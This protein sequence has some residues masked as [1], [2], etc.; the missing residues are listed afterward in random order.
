MGLGPFDLT[1][2]PFLALYA[3]VFVLALLA[4]LWL[5]QWLRPDGRSGMV[6]DADRLAY[7]A[8]CTSRYAETRMTRLYTR[9][10]LTLDRKRGVIL[11]GRP[12]EAE[13]AAD[14]AVL[15]LPSPTSSAALTK[16]LK[17]YAELIG[18]KLVEAGLLI[19]PATAWHMRLFQTLPLLVLLAFGATKW[20][21]GTLRDK[22]VG[23]LTASLVVILLAAIVRFA[24]VN[25]RTQAGETVLG[26]ARRRQ[27]RLRRAAPTAEAALAVALF[28]TVALVGSTWSDLHLLR[29][30]SG[31][32]GDGGSG[33]GSDGGGGCGGGGCGG[34]GG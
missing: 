15:A 33:C 12:A 24:A 26:D 17:P 7:L 3:V 8:G 1:G 29:R 16:A 6:Q 25:R 30:D 20:E 19:D 4:S 9:G 23:F 22:P 2:G 11:R 32:G 10:D 13:D 27:D 34:C 21:I 28:G 14:K 18:Q 31:S 5:P